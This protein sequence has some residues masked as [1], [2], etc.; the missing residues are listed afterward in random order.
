MKYKTFE[1]ITVDTNTISHQHLSN[2]YWF[3]KLIRGLE[4]KSP[5][6]EMEFDGV[7]LPYRP[8]ATFDGEIKSLEYKGFLKWIETKD[9]RMAEIIFE[10][11][12]VGEVWPVDTHRSLV[13]N[14]I[15][16]D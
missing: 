3:N 1:N 14:D 8:K 4:Y 12:K 5:R 13:I 16:K 11:V 2:I 15:L 7:I 10:N 6:L 9:G